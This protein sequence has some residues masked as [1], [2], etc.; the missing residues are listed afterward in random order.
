M[1]SLTSVFAICDCSNNGAGEST[2]FALAEDPADSKGAPHIS[3]SV[4]DGW[5]TKVHR[6]QDTDSPGPG[7]ATVPGRG[8]LCEMA[9]DAIKG[10]G[11]SRLVA[12]LMA[13]FSTVVNG[14]L[15]PHAR[16]GGKCVAALAVAG[17]KLDGT[18]LEN[19]QI[20]QIQVA[21]TGFGDKGPCGMFDCGRV[22]SDCA[23]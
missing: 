1:L 20:G 12:A 19:E 7:D 21:L 15:I 13:A 9:G 8:I 5:F 10:K 16:Q 3:H 23:E 2:R 6:G 14:G 11:E 4:R 22:D 18:G 17:S